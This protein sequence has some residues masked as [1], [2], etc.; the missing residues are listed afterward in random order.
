MTK[1]KAFLKQMKKLTDPTN[2]RLVGI[3]ENKSGFVWLQKGPVLF[4]I[5]ENKKNEL[6]GDNIDWLITAHVFFLV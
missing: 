3:I 2:S 5:F 6:C 1:K 4:F